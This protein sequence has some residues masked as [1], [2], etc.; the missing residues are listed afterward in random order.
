MKTSTLA[1][2]VF[3]SL[4]TTICLDST[5]EIC[6]LILSRLLYKTTMTTYFFYNEINKKSKHK[7]ISFQQFLV[8]NA[9]QHSTN[10]QPFSCHFNQILTRKHVSLLL[11]ITFFTFV[12]IVKHLSKYSFRS[13]SQQIYRYLLLFHVHL[14]CIPLSTK[15]LHI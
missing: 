7:H 15:T 3:H 11:L 14:L 13:L 5:R 6:N 8:K 10:S 9:Q 1:N 12:Y 4:F 2:H